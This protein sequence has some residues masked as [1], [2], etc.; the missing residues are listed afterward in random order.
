MEELVHRIVVDLHGELLCR[1][2]ITPNY[3][4]DIPNVK[5]DKS[6]VEELTLAVS[7]SLANRQ[8]GDL[9]LAGSKLAD[10]IIGPSLLG[11]LETA[12]EESEFTP[13]PGFPF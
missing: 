9:R 1:T 2:F 7:D 6:R 3:T 8:L 13:Y 10:K 12:A 5:F 11:E 4:P